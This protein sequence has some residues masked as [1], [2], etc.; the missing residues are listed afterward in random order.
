[1]KEGHSIISVQ[2]PADLK[3]R[4]LEISNMEERS[5]AAQ[6]RLFLRKSVESWNE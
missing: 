6:V 1:M 5:F 3:Q 2:I 4:I